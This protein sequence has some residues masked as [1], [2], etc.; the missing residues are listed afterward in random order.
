MKKKPT[1]KNKIKY[2]NRKWAQHMGRYFPIENRP[3]STRRCS[4]L[5]AVRESDRN[6]AS[7]N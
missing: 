7:Y 1:V 4:I 6:K 3:M 2:P 5:P